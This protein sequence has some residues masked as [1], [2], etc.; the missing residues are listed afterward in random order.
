[1]A[2]TDTDCGGGISCGAGTTCS[3]DRRCIPFGGVPCGSG[4]C[5]AGSRCGSGNL[6]MNVNDIDCGGGQSC[7]IGSQCMPGGGCM[8]AGATACG[9]YYCS[10]G[11]KCASG[12][13]CILLDSMD[14]GDGTS[15]PAG[16][17][18]GPAGLGRNFRCVP[19][20]NS[21]LPW[22]VQTREK[23]GSVV[24]IR[25]PDKSITRVE[26]YYD[27]GKWRWKVTGP[28]PRGKAGGKYESYQD[29]ARFGC[30]AT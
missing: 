30:G 1:M 13:R 9:S 3:A 29:A 8:P 28:G 6:C 17:R 2:P 14:C 12:K 20:K 10:N 24:T 11:S 15:C 23:N 16:S 27:W 19:T 25:C 21:I 26:K 22:T 4:Y 18:C 7:R 5:P